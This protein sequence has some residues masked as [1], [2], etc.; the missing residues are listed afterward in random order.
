MKL[1][2]LVEY[3]TGLEYHEELNEKFWHDN[4]LRSPVQKALENIANAFIKFL[5][6]KK[7]KVKDIVLTGSNANY[8][9]GP[10]SDLDLHIVI[11]YSDLC[12]DCKEFNIDD[13]FKAKKSL[14]N[15]NHDIKVK[16]QEVELYAQSFE[17]KFSGNS[18]M[19]SIKNKKW[20]R[21]PAHIKDLKYDTKLIKRKADF[22]MREIDDL[23]DNHETS[24]EKIKNLKNK[25][26][27][28]RRKSV[29]NGGEFSLENLVFKTLRNN[30]Y[31][32]K[33][34][35]YAQKVDDKDLSLE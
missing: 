12:D 22:L 4:K 8:N 10:Q 6:V 21:E 32:D 29:S 35:K 28:M 9:W 3:K 13:C 23:V 33:L 1:I 25:I 20:I 26:K 18:G 11:D 17:E 16:D 30:G 27:N 14:W 15:Q 34:Y 7:T 5:D 19:Y 31:M 24:E 2:H